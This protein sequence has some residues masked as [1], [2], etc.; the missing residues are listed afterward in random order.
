MIKSY[1]RGEQENWDLNLGCL[2]F[3]YRSIPQESSGLTPF[4]LMM[5]REACLPAELMYGSQCNENG[6]I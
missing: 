1:L 5:G 4:M 2:A 3:A 6:E